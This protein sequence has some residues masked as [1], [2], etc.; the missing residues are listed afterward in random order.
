MKPYAN[1]S[2]CHVSLQAQVPAP[3]GARLPRSPARPE[4]GHGR[5]PRQGYICRSVTVR[6]QKLVTEA[7]HGN[8]AECLEQSCA[9]DCYF[10]ALECP[11]TSDIAE[12]LGACK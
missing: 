3:A 6:P 9:D 11:W 4:T 1:R 8:Q 5:R 2:P 10:I 7:G 12:A